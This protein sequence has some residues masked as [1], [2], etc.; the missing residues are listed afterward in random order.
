MTVPLKKNPL[1]RCDKGLLNF[2]FPQGIK[3]IKLLFQ[4]EQ[5]KR[6]NDCLFSF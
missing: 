6:K 4:T 2:V 3:S 5:L 1:P